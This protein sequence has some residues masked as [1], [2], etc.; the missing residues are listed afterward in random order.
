MDLRFSVVLSPSVSFSDS[1]VIVFFFNSVVNVFFFF[2]QHQQ[3][4]EPLLVAF[5][6]FLPLSFATVLLD[7]LCRIHVKQGTG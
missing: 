4:L 7:T 5:S 1:V 3:T 6:L 2:I